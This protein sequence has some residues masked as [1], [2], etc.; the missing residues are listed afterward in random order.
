MQS[1]TEKQIILVENMTRMLGIDFPISS[2]EFTKRIYSAWIKANIEDYKDHMASCIY[3]EDYL[4]EG[5][6]NDVW[7]EHY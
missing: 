3:D 6:N 1:P 2:K 5:C 4:Y 7:C